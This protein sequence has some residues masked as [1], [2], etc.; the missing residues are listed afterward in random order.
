MRG[1]AARGGRARG[2]L[3]SRSPADDG[4]I[5][6]RPAAQ[7]RPAP[8][9]AA[10]SGAAPRD[11]AGRR[12]AG[13]G[14]VPLLDRLLRG[15]TRLPTRCSSAN[16]RRSTS[17]TSSCWRW[18]CSR[19]RE[20]IRRSWSGRFE[21][22]MVDEFQDTNRRQLEILRLLERE[23]LFTVGDEFQAI[24][25]FR[26]AEVAIFRERAELLSRTGVEPRADA[27]LPQP[28]RAGGDGRRRIRGA[29]G[30]LHPRARGPRE[31]DPAGGGAG[32]RAAADPEGR[33][34]GGSAASVAAIAAGLPA[35]RRSG[36]RPRRGC[37]PAA[38][39]SWS[40]P[41]RRA[42]ARS[43]CCCGRSGTSPCTSA[44]CSSRGSPRS[45]RPGPTGR[46]AR[47]K[48]C[49]PTCGCS[50]TRSTRWRCTRS[51][52]G[53]LGGVSRDGLALLALAAQERGVAGLRAGVGGRRRELGLAARRR[54]GAASG[55]C[56]PSSS[57]SAPAPR[58]GRSG[59]L[60]ARA[61][62]AAGAAERAR[63]RA[64]GGR[65]RAGQRPQARP[66]GAPLRSERGPRPAGLPRPRRLPEGAGPR[67]ARR[68]RPALSDS[69]RGA[70]DEHPRRQGAGVPG[71][72]RRRPRPRAQHADAGTA[73]RRRAHRPAAAAPR[74]RR[75]HA[76]RSSTRRCARSAAPRKPSRRT[77]SCTWR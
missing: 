14:R 32:G 71:R 38:W 65:R 63:P 42:P 70:A 12:R 64:G 28:A 68:T 41:G 9:A 44:R 39:R 37:S 55:F 51:L 19:G 45:P 17:T 54:A 15:F 25:G 40:P 60:I 11:E 26:H 3:R 43:S 16:A 24:Y 57:R 69:R 21:L 61:L 62:R 27:Q 35:R 8:P 47:S 73:R 56:V 4:R 5:R 13:G 6:P 18:S 34:G 75:E 10:G 66:P 58:C 31:P 33:L 72:V 1:E 49:S 29:P 53:P 20:E 74:R 22:L 48:T 67:R 50:P 7:P 30:G 23:N 77:G 76:R 2:H 59:E 46:A 52:A 36:A